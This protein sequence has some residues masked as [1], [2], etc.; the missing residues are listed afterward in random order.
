MNFIGLVIISDF[1]DYFFV[2]V[3][4]ERLSK[5]ISDGEIDLLDKKLT[6]EALTMIETTTSEQA[7][8]KIEGNRLR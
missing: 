5:L 7:R 6:L 2:T 1:D 3:K 8:F 4:D